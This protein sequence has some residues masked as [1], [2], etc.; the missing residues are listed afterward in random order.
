MATI[1]E[2]LREKLEKRA[3]R[4]K[5]IINQ[6]YKNSQSDFIKVLKKIG[7]LELI[8]NSRDGSRIIDYF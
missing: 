7:K 1:H 2:S 4:S 6:N 8:N 3:D 5:S